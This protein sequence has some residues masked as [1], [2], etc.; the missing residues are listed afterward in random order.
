LNSILKEFLVQIKIMSDNGNISDEE[1][2]DGEEA[3]ARRAEVRAGYRKLMD[4]IAGKEE[5]LVSI[6]NHQLLGYMQHN[7]ELFSNVSAPQEAVMDAQVIKHLSRLCRQQAEQMSANIS[8]FRYEEYAERLVVSMRGE[9]GQQLARR[10]WVMLGQQ[11]KVFFRK[12]PFLTCMYGALDTTPPPPKEKKTREPKSRQATKV[13]DLV[14]T[15]ETVL[16]EAE[17]S[18]NQ[19]EQ[20]VM[21]VFKCLVARYRELEKKPVNYF[22]FVMHPTCFGTSIENIFHVSFLVKEGKADISLCEKTGLPMIK[23]LSKRKGEKDGES[24]NQ[25][26]MNMNMEDWERIVMEEDIREVMIDTVGEE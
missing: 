15:K 2:E 12:S 13:S 16:A 25:V 5:E 10:K 7:A 8:Q 19:T 23:P 4:E 21:H 18:E 6:E 11:A 17:K 22:K 3:E 24:K 9:G 14:E 20:M 26:V 1:V